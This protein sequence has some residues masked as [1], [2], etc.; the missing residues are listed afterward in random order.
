MK[1]ISLS[2]LLAAS[3]VLLLA[4]SV[5]VKSSANAS[6]GDDQLRQLKLIEQQ[7]LSDKQSEA[8]KHKEREQAFLAARDQQAEK[9]AELQREEAAAKAEYQRLKASVESGGAEIKALKV[10]LGERAHH[11]QDLFA[12]ARQVA[13]D[14]QQELS[15]SLVSAQYP[16]LLG[17]LEPLRK[18]QTVL[19]AAQLQALWQVLSADIK[20]SGELSRF[21]A[22]VYQQDGSSQ[23]TEV[24]RLGPF[25]ARDQENYLQLLPENGRLQ[26][27]AP[28]PD[29]MPQAQGSD[30][31]EALI[32]PTRG[33]LFKQSVNQAG[34]AERLQQGGYVGAV[35]V[36]L[37]ILGLLFTGYKMLSLAAL[38]K[39]I[40]AQL[41]VP[42]TIDK[43]NPL[44]RILA[45]GEALMAAPKENDSSSH[46]AVQSS[47]QQS[48]NEP[49]LEAKLQEAILRE[50]PVLDIGTGLIKLLATVAPL[51]G[52]LG[53]VT[54]MIATFQAIS[55]HGTGDPRL[56]AGGIS[57]ALITTVLGLVVAIPL[58][59]GHSLVASRVKNLMLILSQESLALVAQVL[60]QSAAKTAASRGQGSGSEPAGAGA[61][62]QVV[63][64]Q[65]LKD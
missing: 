5:S 45:A 33:Q 35:I 21:N 28:A 59:F 39:R 20:A 6:L 56:M 61:G 43:S 23:S 22:P 13:G 11:L 30:V 18:E 8:R 32:D 37:G 12:L 42:T 46:N 29:G 63:A 38:K 40:D 51:L 24:L 55:L 17:Q 10:Q 25:S 26:V 2:A 54:G 27:L 3:F 47:A 7:I 9:L 44:G 53:T 34:W 36:L 64:A 52:L 41:A 49:V 1:T 57:Q 15:G 50:A 60:D 4:L 14:T 62:E 19:E 58:L 65:A 31:F 16:S 48:A